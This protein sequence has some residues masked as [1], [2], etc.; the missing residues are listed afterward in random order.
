MNGQLAFS[1]W[2]ICIM[3]LSFCIFTFWKSI[4]IINVNNTN[5]NSNTKI[6]FNVKIRSRDIHKT[7]YKE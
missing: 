4:Y 7:L 6:I 5:Y 2:D 3:A 1:R